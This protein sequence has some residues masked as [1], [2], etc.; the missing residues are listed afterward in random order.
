MLGPQLATGAVLDTSAAGAGALQSGINGISNLL[1]QLP[2][3]IR[4]VVVADGGTA[5]G[6]LAADPG[7]DRGGGRAQRGPLGGSRHTDAAISAAAVAGCP[8]R[9]ASPGWCCSTPVRPTPAASRRPS[10]AGGWWTAGVVLRW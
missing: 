6:A 8:E 3:G 7:R 5:H 1:L 10:S 2:D 4:N 9:R